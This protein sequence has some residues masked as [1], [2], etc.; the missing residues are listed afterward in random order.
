MRPGALRSNIRRMSHARRKL[1]DEQVAE[2]R[3]RFA[4]GES[5][6]SLAKRYGVSDDTIRSYTIASVGKRYGVTR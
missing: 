5:R 2:L 4:E 3:R 6:P 1:D